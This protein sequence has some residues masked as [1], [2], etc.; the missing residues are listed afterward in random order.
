MDNIELKSLISQ[1]ENM[2]KYEIEVKF[3]DDF[4]KSENLRVKE[5]SKGFFWNHFVTLFER[6]DADEMNTLDIDETFVAEQQAIDL[7]SKLKNE[8]MKIR[9]FSV[10]EFEEFLILIYIQILFNERKKKEMKK[11]LIVIGHR[12]GKG[13]NVAKG[14][15]KAG[16]EAI[17]IE[18]VAADMRLGDVMKEKNA[19]LG[20][21]FCGSGGAGAITAHNKYGYKA[22]HN[23]RT[24]EAGVQAIKEGYEVI[25]FGFM[26]T[27]ELGEKLTLKYLEMHGDKNE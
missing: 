26:D 12:L 21:S 5:A 19:D 22:K 23:L 8:L 20:I 14:I 3:I 16:G 18:G 4:L 25:G 1:I 6:I 13:N 27:E 24:V 7:T 17:V 9:K 10:T 11:P 15:V 2:E